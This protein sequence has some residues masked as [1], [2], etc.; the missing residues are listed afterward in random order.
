MNLEELRKSSLTRTKAKKE[1]EEVLSL[2]LEGSRLTVAP[3]EGEEEPK[4][5]SE[6]LPLPKIADACWVRS[7]GRDWLWGITLGGFLFQL[8]LP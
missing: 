5:S 2:K 7:G 6:Y 8:A 3:A 1:E 4:M